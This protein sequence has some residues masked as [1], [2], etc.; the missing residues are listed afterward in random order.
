MIISYPYNDFTGQVRGGGE[1]QGGDR[2]ARRR[3]AL[4]RGAG[5]HW[6]YD[7]MFAILYYT[8]LYYTILHYTI[9]YYTILI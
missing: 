5:G 4:P 3:P 8:I 6:C 2:E 9:P 7:M 1:G